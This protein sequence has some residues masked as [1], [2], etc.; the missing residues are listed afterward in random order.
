MARQS[1][2]QIHAVG[3]G[4]CAACA[5]VFA[6]LAVT[7][8]V[9]FDMCRSTLHFMSTS[10]RNT[11]DLTSHHSSVHRDAWNDFCLP[12]KLAEHSVLLHIAFQ[13]WSWHLM[14]MAIIVPFLCALTCFETLKQESVIWW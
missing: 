9:V 11:S 8:D 6:K 2:G 3:A 4:L 13:S 1:A 14:P 10:Q 12:V 7:S 5:S